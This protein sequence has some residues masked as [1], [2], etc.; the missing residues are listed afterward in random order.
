MPTCQSKELNCPR[1]TLHVETL[2]LLRERPR[3]MT[4]EKLLE[5]MAIANCRP[6][7]VHWIHGF[8]SGR[9]ENVDVD[10][11]QALYEILS[12]RLLTFD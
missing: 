6:V 5:R 1:G 4:Y 10:R 12:G 3:Y 9:F 8:Q 11:I 2:R 7:T